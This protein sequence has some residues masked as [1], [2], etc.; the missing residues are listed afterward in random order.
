MSIKDSI[1]V[2]ELVAALNVHVEFLN[3][4]G[5]DVAEYSGRTAR[6]IWNEEAKLRELLAKLGLTP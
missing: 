3:S 4:V 1:E 5:D 6:R 2:A